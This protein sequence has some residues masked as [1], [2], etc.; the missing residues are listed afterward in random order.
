MGACCS[1]PNDG[2]TTAGSK[3]DAS[4][5][6][7]KQV[8][9]EVEKYPELMT[10]RAAFDTADVDNTGTLPPDR[11]VQLVLGAIEGV[12]I[13]DIHDEIPEN[14][15]PRFQRL[16]KRLA[17]NDGNNDGNKEESSTG[18]TQEELL[19]SLAAYAKSGVN[20][21]SNASQNVKQARPTAQID[22]DLFTELAPLLDA[23]ASACATLT[24]GGHGEFDVSKRAVVVIDEEETAP[25]PAPE[26]KK[27]VVP[28]KKPAPKKSPLPPPVDP[29]IAAA[30]AAS[31]K[32]AKERLQR[33]QLKSKMPSG[34]YLE[35]I[36][37]L[38]KGGEKFDNHEFD[39]EYKLSSPGN[40]PR[41]KKE[42]GK[43][44]AEKKPKQTHTKKPAKKEE[45]K[46][47]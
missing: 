13:G 7:E 43:K 5:P 1:A 46:K 9:R 36:P 20:R 37:S 3:Y 2:D 45:F 28:V 10:L 32:E 11:C 30:D 35:S 39:K 17:L 4:T 34:K 25:A 33:I 14:P 44:S 41:G 18:V 24:K 15:T 6:K 27:T 8:L 12:T 26:P 31:A 21:H 23:S 16:A 42:G 19:V 47:Y 38:P 40:S 22:V 29:A